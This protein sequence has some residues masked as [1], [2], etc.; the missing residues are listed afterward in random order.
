MRSEIFGS[1]RDEGSQE[2]A[3]D[4]RL[5][6]SILRGRAAPAGQ[7][8]CVHALGE[9][10]RL[11]DR[12]GEIS[13]DGLALHPPAQEVRPQKF[14]ERRGVLGKSPGAPQL[15]CQG[16]ER[17]VNQTADRLGNVLVGAAATRSIEWM[18]PAPVVQNN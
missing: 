7:V 10:Q 12:M 5:I 1:S 18:H 15:A 3:S 17:I 2:L 9:L 14:A 11:L 4:V 16:A 6:R 13:L 8:I